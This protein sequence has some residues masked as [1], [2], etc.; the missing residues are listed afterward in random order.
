LDTK[1]FESLKTARTGTSDTD[2][3]TQE[4]PSQLVVCIEA[5]ALTDKDTAGKVMEVGWRDASRDYI[6]VK[7]DLA[8]TEYTLEWKG[9]IYLAEGRKIYG[10]VF[11]PTSLD[12]LALVANG[13]YA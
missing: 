8:D 6:L 3:E 4:I 9:K 7:K 12:D 11:S 5:I 10:K 1:I 2:L 13:I